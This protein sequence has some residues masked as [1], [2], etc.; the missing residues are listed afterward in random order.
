MCESERQSTPL[1]GVVHPPTRAAFG[2][3]PA[4][5]RE[6]E[7]ARELWTDTEDICLSCFRSSGSE[8]EENKEVGR[9]KDSCVALSSPEF[10]LWYTI[11]LE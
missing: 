11:D 9:K 2:L 5:D 1:V 3:L 4:S 7:R 10:S 6:R 8:K